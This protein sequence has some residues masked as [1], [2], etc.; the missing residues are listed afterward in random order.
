MAT[1]TEYFAKEFVVCDYYQ[2]ITALD[3]AVLSV[4]DPHEMAKA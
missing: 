4:Q 1:P 2:F 3:E